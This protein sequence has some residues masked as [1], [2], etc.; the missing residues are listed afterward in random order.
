MR[1]ITTL[2]NFNDPL[3]ILAFSFVIFI[4]FESQLPG[5][6]SDDIVFGGTIGFTA[7]I[8]TMTD[9]LFGDLFFVPTQILCTDVE[10]EFPKTNGSAETFAV[11]NF[12]DR[13]PTRV[14]SQPVGDGLFEGSFV[15]AGMTQA[16]DHLIGVPSRYG[17][18]S[19]RANSHCQ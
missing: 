7:V 16:T 9:I 10:E 3:R 19:R 11:G 1:N 13:L 4:Q 17:E 6:D 2:G 15:N 12:F 18:D 14:L 5:R 8:Y